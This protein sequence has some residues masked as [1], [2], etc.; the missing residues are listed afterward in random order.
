MMKFYLNYENMIV[1]D[2]QMNLYGEAFFV[3]E[4]DFV[5]IFVI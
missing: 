3:N 4:T 5:K 2:C 1:F